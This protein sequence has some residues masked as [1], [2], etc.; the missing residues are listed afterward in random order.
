MNEKKVEY[1][2]LIYDLIFVYLIG[3]TNSLMHVVENGFFGIGVFEGYII[4][5]IVIL[6]IWNH[7]TLLINRYG[8]NGVAEHVFL[9]INM[10]LLYFIGINT[11]SDW[12]TGYIAYHVAWGLILINLGL[13]YLLQF[14]RFSVLCE[15][16]RKYIIGHAVLLFVQAASVFALIPLFAAFGIAIPWLPV[17]I[18]FVGGFFNG[19]IHT[20][21][22]VNF[23]HLSERVML[24]VVFT[25][26]E[27]I[28]SLAGYFEG[29]FTVNTLYFSFFAFLIV[30]GLLISYG[31]LYNYVIDREQRTTGKL[32]MILHIFLIIALN[33]ISIALEYMK[34]PEVGTLEKHIFIIISFFAYYIFL[35]AIGWHTREG[36]PP[37]RRVI[38]RTCIMSLAAAFLI[39]LF[40]DDPRVS[41]AV[42]A[43]YIYLMFGLIVQ[44]W[45][46]AKVLNCAENAEKTCN[47]G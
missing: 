12:G 29:G 40:H 24:Y 4:S 2:E 16:E 35:F 21:M 11:Q 23:E 30:A 38:V 19:R 42:S 7:S 32:Y 41:I 14:R 6:Q 13:Q 39:V 28:V 31:Y 8:R 5:T 9:F 27:M 20:D 17:V 3:R 45:R 22:S 37:G 44:R 33:N 34:N 43:A 10:Y 25:F 1:I 36:C 18:G 46:P 26:G 47:F 15:E